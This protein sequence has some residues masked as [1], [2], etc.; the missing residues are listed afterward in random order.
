MILEFFENATLFLK[1][2]NH[3]SLL[4]DSTMSSAPKFCFLSASLQARKHRIRKKINSK[5]KSIYM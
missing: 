1:L 3:T 5:N 4:R 2:M